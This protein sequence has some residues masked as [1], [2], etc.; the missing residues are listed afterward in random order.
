MGDSKP[1]SFETSLA[2]GLQAKFMNYKDCLITNMHGAA[3]FHSSDFRSAFESLAPGMGCGGQAPGSL[4]VWPTY[5][6]VLFVEPGSVIGDDTLYQEL[7][8]TGKFHNIG[9]AMSEFT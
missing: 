3:F 9:K 1:F 4:L 8:T 7:N 6:V 2:S 5:D